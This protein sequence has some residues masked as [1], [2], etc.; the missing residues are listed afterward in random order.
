M[1][2]LCEPKGYDEEKMDK[3]MENEQFI[4]ICGGDRD[5]KGNPSWQNFISQRLKNMENNPEQLRAYNTILQSIHSTDPKRHRL[6]FLE[7]I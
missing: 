1:I 4:N 6:F 3:E 5:K 7:G 2:G